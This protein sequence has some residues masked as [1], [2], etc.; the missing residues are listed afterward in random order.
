MKSIV[1][2]QNPGRQVKHSEKAGIHIDWKAADNHSD[3][4]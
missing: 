4:Y 1:I 2:S 3:V